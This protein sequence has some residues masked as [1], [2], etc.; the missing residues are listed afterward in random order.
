MRASLK[1]LAIGSV[2]GMG[3]L[4]AV[5]SLLDCAARVKAF[6]RNLDADTQ[7]DSLDSFFDALEPLTPLNHELKRCILSE[8]EISDDASPGLKSVRRQ[9]QTANERIRSQLNSMISSQTTRTYLQENVVT[10][11]NGRYCIPV[12][13]EY[14]GQ[15]PG[16]IHD[17]SSTGSTLFIEPMAVV[18]LN[19]DIKELILKEQDRKDSL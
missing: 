17:Q 13:Q 7:E 10:M 8:E 4:L 5:S 9:M 15:V 1:R 12:K 3:E 14:R 11:R 18:K 19:N 2:L 6:S 16:M